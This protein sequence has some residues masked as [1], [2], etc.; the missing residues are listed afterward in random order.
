[1]VPLSP[2]WQKS[3]C[4]GCKPDQNSG[5]TKRRK[6]LSGMSESIRA[7]TLRKGR[8][9]GCLMRV[10]LRV[11]HKERPGPWGHHGQWLRAPLLDTF[12]RCLVHGPFSS[13]LHLPIHK[14]SL[15]LGKQYGRS[16]QNL[17]KHCI[18]PQPIL[19]STLRLVPMTQ[20][21]RDVVLCLSSWEW[22]V[23]RGLR[24]LFAVLSGEAVV[25]SHAR[26]LRTKAKLSLPQSRWGHPARQA[27]HAEALQGRKYRSEWMGE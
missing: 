10:G 2:P 25:T 12:C 5:D 15:G 6:E 13:C 7:A 11:C 23:M 14:E 27:V 9:W 22:Q 1:M 16:D 17:S 26:L 3:P 8:G 24:K 20:S 4:W 18:N 21:T 19:T